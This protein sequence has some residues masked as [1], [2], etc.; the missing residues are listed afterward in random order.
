MNLV[1]PMEVIP[2][3]YQVRAIGARVTIVFSDQDVLLVD[4]GGRGSL[5]LITAGLKALGSSL[6]R[7]RLIVLTHY[8]P[9]HC[10]GLGQLVERT[11]A[12]VAAHTQEARIISGEESLPNPFHSRLLAGLT[13]P[14]LPLLYD[15]PV[16]VDFCLDDGDTL[17]LAEEIR[18]IHT[19]GHTQGSICLRVASKKLLIVGDALQYRSRRLGLPA[20]AV[21]HNPHQA[22]ES[23]QR[24]LSL[25]FDTIC[26][27]HF[28]SLK[29]G[30]REA[31]RRL[32]REAK[33]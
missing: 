11:G 5:G 29:H 3:V 14:I 31:L 7:V 24:L 2:G 9:D 16:K 22:E 18:V 17:P 6:D 30:A 19:P 28:P 10:G 23:L 20:A 33:C 15:Q 4:A 25:D 8:H 27:S 12:P 21:T 1:R 26:F 32:L 13:H